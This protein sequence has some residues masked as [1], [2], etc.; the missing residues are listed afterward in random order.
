MNHTK[1]YYIMEPV[2]KFH[3]T[4]AKF[5]ELK[6]EY[7]ALVAAEH[8]RAVSEEAPKMVESDDLNPDF[9]SF[10][11]G[12]ESMRVRIDELEN[13]FANHQLIKKPP[14]EKASLVDLG[15]TVKIE[16]NGKKDEFTI[17][18]TLEAH[19][20]LGK[21]SNESPVGAALIGHKIGDEVVHEKTKYKIKNIKYE[22]G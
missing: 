14:K 2:K 5:Q 17:V 9:V 6:K 1:I 19:P 4:K 13:I 16:A 15:A 18:G 3:V 10:Q 11:E 22:I 7:D 21:I 8:K 12:M 20:E